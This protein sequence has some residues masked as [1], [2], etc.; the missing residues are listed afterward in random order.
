MMRIAVIGGKDTRNS[1]ACQSVSAAT[2][3]VSGLYHPMR[4]SPGISI[5]ESMARISPRVAAVSE[6]S[7]RLLIP[8]KSTSDSNPSHSHFIGEIEQISQLSLIY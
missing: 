5:R 1:T 7:S 3:P 8:L 2:Y 6:S 4:L